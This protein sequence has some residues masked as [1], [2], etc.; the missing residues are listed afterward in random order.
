MMN[1]IIDK[2]GSALNVHSSFYLLCFSENISCCCAP[3]DYKPANSPTQSPS[4]TTTTTTTSIIFNTNKTSSATSTCNCGIPNKPSRIFGGSETVPNEFP[5][6]VY[7]SIGGSSLCGGAL[8]SSQHVLTAAH[9][10]DGSVTAPDLRVYVGT[11]DRTDPGQVVSVSTIS[12]NPSWTGSVYRGSDSAVLT[13]AEAVTFSDAVRPL[14]M[15]VDPSRSYAGHQ[16]IASGWGRDDNSD[17]PD[18]LRK[19]NVE[20]IS[21]DQCRN[22]WPGVNE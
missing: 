4:T 11:H 15:S 19:V 18:K 1:T 5:W 20:I 3:Q 9:C 22:T 6:V 17:I 12:I 2:I 7:L 10:V 13:L 8:I 14:C 21:N 16:A